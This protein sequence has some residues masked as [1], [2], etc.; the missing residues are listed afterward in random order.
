MRTSGSVRGDWGNP[1]PYRD[2]SLNCPGATK[3][4]L[5]RTRILH[6]VSSSSAAQARFNKKVGRSP[7]QEVVDAE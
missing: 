4:H 7:N 1:V 3:R 6:N 5:T 2:I